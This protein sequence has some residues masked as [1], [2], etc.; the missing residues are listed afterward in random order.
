M[1]E[2]RVKVIETDAQGR[3]TYFDACCKDE[4][5]ARQLA[6]LLGGEAYLM[7]WGERGKARDAVG[8]QLGLFDR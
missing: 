3:R 6:E 2:W 7:D 5:D 8:R 1:E 4:A